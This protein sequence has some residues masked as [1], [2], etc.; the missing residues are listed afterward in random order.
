[1]RRFFSDFGHEDDVLA[2]IKSV[3]RGRID[4]QLIAEHDD[5][6]AAIAHLHEGSSMNRP[7]IRHYRQSSRLSFH[8]HAQA[9][10]K[11]AARHPKK[12]SWNK[13]CGGLLSTVP[14]GT[15]AHCR[16]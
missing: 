6:V 14:I 1:M 9:I 2:S 4:I 11:Q 15:A 3:E 10:A 5:Q 13:I 16:A 12:P 7:R 8:T